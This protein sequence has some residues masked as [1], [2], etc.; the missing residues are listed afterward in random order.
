MK[1][2]ICDR[3]NHTLLNDAP[4]RP[5]LVLEF[6]GQTKP[7]EPHKIDDNGIGDTYSTYINIFDPTSRLCREI[8]L[9]KYMLEKNKAKQPRS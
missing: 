4:I 3:K 9:R 5:L 1:T 8:R 2:V 6:L 7:R